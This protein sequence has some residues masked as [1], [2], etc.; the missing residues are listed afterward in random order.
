M[1]KRFKDNVEGLKPEVLQTL[2]AQ[3]D[4]MNY[5]ELCKVE[6]YCTDELFWQNF[7]RLGYAQA[8]T[9]A[10]AIEIDER[11]GGDRKQKMMLYLTRFCDIMM[12]QKVEFLSKGVYRKSIT[13][14]VGDMEQVKAPSTRLIAENVIYLMARRMSGYDD[15][16]KKGV[17]KI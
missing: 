6:E 4:E 1:F 16:G 17:V 12:K 8:A 3:M 10:C 7:M 9:F 11:R 2:I 5:F 15:L 13:S 14:A